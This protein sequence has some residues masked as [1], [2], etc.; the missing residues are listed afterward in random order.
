MAEPVFISV[1]K[2]VGGPLCIATD[3]GDRV[4]ERIA[5]HLREGRRIVLS[6]AGVEMVI[7]AF[8][9]SAIG[10]LYGEFS[11]AQVDSLVVRSDS[12]RTSGR[13]AASYS[14]LP[15]SRWSFRPFSVPLSVNSMASFLKRRWI[16]WWSCGIC[17]KASTRS[18]NP[19]AAGPKLTIAT[20]WRMRSEERRV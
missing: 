20:P 15:G 11:E 4:H 9:S 16:P 8:L 6:F 19:H 18:L 10:Q 12:R 7:P 13:D 5:P 1:R 17:Q 3:D 14:L 2:I